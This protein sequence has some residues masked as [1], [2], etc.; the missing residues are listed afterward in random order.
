MQNSL[1]ELE[2]DDDLVP[3]PIFVSGVVEGKWILLMWL[4]CFV[5]TMTVCLQS[6]YETDVTPATFP[7]VWGIPSWVA[8]G[9]CLPWLVANIVTIAFCF[10]YM[11]DGD[12]G[13][14]E[15]EA[16]SAGGTI[17]EGANNA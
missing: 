3:D 12:L 14:D 9:I 7:T 8:W 5:W 10:G 6:G 16:K 15:S 17:V 2:Q 11:K 4:G 1:A 13:V